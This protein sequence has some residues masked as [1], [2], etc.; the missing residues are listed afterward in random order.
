MCRDPR[1]EVDGVAVDVAL[2]DDEWTDGDGSVRIRQ[3]CLGDGGHELADARDRL[4]R[5]AEPAEDPVAQ[6]LDHPSAMV[7]EDA[8]GNHVKVRREVRSSFVATDHRELGVSGKVD[9]GDRRRVRSAWLGPACRGDGP[10]HEA[11]DPLEDLV[12]RVS[13]MK[14]DQ[15]VRLERR[16]DD[17]R[18]HR[19][20]LARTT[21]EPIRR[22][23]AVGIEQ[24]KGGPG[25]PP[26]AVTGDVGGTQSQPGYIVDHRPE[27]DE[28]PEEP[29]LVRRDRQVE[30]WD[31]EPESRVDRRQ[32]SA[33]VA[34]G[35]DELAEGVVRLA[36]RR[37]HLG[38]PAERELVRVRRPPDIVE[39]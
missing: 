21:A 36:R 13:V 19:C 23:S 32:V 26:H 2:T 6:L 8:T 24:V 7:R 18:Q 1:G 17:G 10:F 22:R 27:V 3:A 35:R 9:E 39:R 16:Q 14:P 20:I 5:G 29:L 34:E 28:A 25:D 33:A 12:F 15:E 31:R 11:D 38:D 4:D 37:E 30:R